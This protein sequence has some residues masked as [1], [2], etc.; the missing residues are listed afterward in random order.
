MAD[1]TLYEWYSAEEAISLFG[2]PD[3]AQRLCNGQWV[4]L[5]NTAICLT[6]IG[7]KWEASHFDK[8]ASFYWVADQPYRVSDSPGAK[9]VPAQVLAS[10]ERKYSIRL[11]VRPRQA[12]KY[13]YVGELTSSHVLVKSIDADRGA[14]HFT[15]IPTVP[16]KVLAEL[17]GLR[18]GDVDLAGLD[19]ALDRLKQP[20]TVHDRLDVLRH[21]VNFWHGPIEPEDGMSGVEQVGGVPLPFPLQFWYG[22]AGKRTEVMTGQNIFFTPRD[23]RRR[24]TILAIKEDRL[25]FHVE[26][27][28][29]YEWSTL[30]YGDDPQVFGRYECKG[31]APRPNTRSSSLDRYW[32]RAGNSYR[33]EKALA[34]ARKMRCPCNGN[35]AL[36][37]R[38]IPPLAIPPWLG[39]QFFARR[40]A[41]MCAAENGQHEGKKWYSVW[42]G[43]KTEHPLQFIKPLLDK[44]WGL[45]SI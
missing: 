10:S 15:L 44:S 16:S 39:T 18:L 21:L 35:R 34:R 23:Y 14:A 25:H 29:V 17:G 2:A 8:A 43:A 3:Q 6:N 13:L 26:N 4:I 33:F 20:T 32:T 38:H 45:V 31:S 37:P 1:P 11:F 30:P 27:Q 28:G 7:R 5:D 36:S 42:I 24:N 40:G 9:F 22:W 41:F 12:E 19:Q